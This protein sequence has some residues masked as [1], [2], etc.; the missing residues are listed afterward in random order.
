MNRY[1]YVLPLEYQNAFA[2][3]WSAQMPSST[4]IQSQGQLV[5]S[6]FLQ[7]STPNIEI[8]RRVPR[9]KKNDEIKK[10]HTHTHYLSICI[11]LSLLV[12]LPMHF[13]FPGRKCMHQSLSLFSFAKTFGLDPDQTRMEIRK[14]CFVNL[15]LCACDRKY[16]KCPTKAK[17]HDK[18]G[19]QYISI[20]VYI[21]R[22]HARIQ[23]GGKGVRT[24]P[25][26]HPL[27]ITKI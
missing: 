4:V 3:S 13:D 11:S 18:M 27:K 15:K 17:A 6:D 9:V 2:R 21:G 22:S 25:P 14:E 5:R 26:P 10:E 12:N 1:F 19:F 8:R 24:P 20:S 23:K 16:A 7:R